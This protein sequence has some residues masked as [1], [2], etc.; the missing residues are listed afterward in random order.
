MN[1]K[2]YGTS[3]LKGYP[4][5]RPGRRHH[6]NRASLDACQNIGDNGIY[7]YTQNQDKNA[8]TNATGANDSKESLKHPEP[9]VYK[10]FK[11]HNGVLRHSPRD[12]ASFRPRQRILMDRG[13][14]PPSKRHYEFAHWRAFASTSQPNSMEI[15]E[16]GS[17]QGQRKTDLPNSC[18]KEAPNRRLIDKAKAEVKACGMSS[19]NDQLPCD[20]GREIVFSGART[21]LVHISNNMGTIAPKEANFYQQYETNRITTRIG[22]WVVDFTVYHIV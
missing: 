3:Q 13:L 2:Q 9:N 18:D 15:A 12:T 17:K 6:T 10:P 14:S 7:Q 5:Y 1:K 22:P 8:G 19:Y 16:S 11:E 20:T 4:A 21:V